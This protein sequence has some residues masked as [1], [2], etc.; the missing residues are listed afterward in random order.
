MVNY[1]ILPAPGNLAGQIEPIGEVREQASN[2]AV[3]NQAFLRGDVLKI[4]ATGTIR[5]CTAADKRP[6]AVCTKAKAMTDSRVEYVNQ[7]DLEISVVADGVIKP[8]NLVMPSATTDG[9]VIIDPGTAADT[10]V[11]QYVKRA[12]YVP[13]GDGQQAPADT[14]AGDIIVIRLM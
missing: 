5:K 13:E 2:L 10:A 9:R 4:T 11:G 1:A 7:K 3:V 6:F 12:Q 8:L 14:I